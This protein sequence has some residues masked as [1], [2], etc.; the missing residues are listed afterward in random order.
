MVSSLL[1]LSGAVVL[2]TLGML[3]WLGVL[4]RLPVSLAYP[5]LSPNF[6]L[7][8]LSAHWLFGETVSFRHWQGIAAITA[9]VLCMGIDL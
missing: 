5:M 2:L 4:Q 7:V 6:I 9:G 8:A 3:A 1:W